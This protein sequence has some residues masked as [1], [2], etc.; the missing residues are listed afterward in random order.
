MDGLIVE[1]AFE[2]AGE[3]DRVEDVAVE[4]PDGLNAARSRSR[5]TARSFTDEKVTPSNTA[6]AS[7]ASFCSAE[8][9]SV[10]TSTEPSTTVWSGS[11]A[12]CPAR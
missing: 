10:R 7:Q 5:L 2:R 1:Q 11:P 12:P 9:L 3:L 4:R 6:R 8:A